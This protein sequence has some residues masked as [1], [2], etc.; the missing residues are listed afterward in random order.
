MRLIRRILGDKRFRFLLVGGL[1]TA[2]G[3]GSFAL[4]TWLGMHYFYATTLATILGVANSYVWNKYFTFRSLKRSGWE[5][6]RFLSVYLVSYG[7]NLGAMRLMVDVWGV[8]QYA[9]GAI[10]IA[11]TT[12]I[13]YAGHN[14]FSFAARAGA[15]DASGG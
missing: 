10:S 1:N 15:G 4:F 13:S 12:V 14:L 8:N 6:V 9:A 2:V 7:L 11:V 3:Y 5:L